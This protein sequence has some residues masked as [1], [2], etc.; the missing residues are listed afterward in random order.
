MYKFRKWILVQLAFLI[1]ASLYIPQ[2]ILP[3]LSN[4][5]QVDPVVASQL[6]TR[7]ML[8]LCMGAFLS[9]FLLKYLSPR[10]VLVAGTLALAVGEYLMAYSTSINE[11]LFIKTAEGLIYAIMLPALMTA[12]AESSGSKGTAVA[13][14]VTASVVGSLFGRGLSGILIASGFH[15][16][17]WILLSS[18]LLL[19]V[20]G[21]L[22]CLQDDL[23]KQHQPETMTGGLKS[24]LKRSDILGSYI[25]IFI[26]TTVFVSVLNYLPFHIR[27]S[28]PG[29]PDSAIAFLYSGY[30]VGIVTSVLSTKIKLILKNDSRVFITGL[31]GMAGG[32]LLLLNSSYWLI[33]IGVACLCG[34]IF[35]LHSGLSTYLNQQLPDYRSLINGIYLTVY[36]LGGALSSTF[37]GTVFMQFG[38]GA[39][40][41]L[42]LLMLVSGFFVALFLYKG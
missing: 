24:L 13:Y 21:L 3:Y 30:A 41:A 34:S 27:D 7:V 12:L 19:T 29:V 9:G 31:L 39:L 6:V 17:P 15:M 38:W 11:A 42:L 37:P 8:L 1:F 23:N 28:L 14:Y 4:Y 16:L 25:L 20:P 18:A 2:P 35:V 33:F 40:L 10:L 5:F 32:I 22:L 36:Y 26:G